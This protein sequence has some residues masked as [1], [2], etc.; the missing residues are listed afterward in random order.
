LS[1]ER[2]RELQRMYRNSSRYI[3]LGA[4]LTVI[5]LACTAL[6]IGRILGSW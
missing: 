1:E 3:W 5:N 4:A 2:L 6:N